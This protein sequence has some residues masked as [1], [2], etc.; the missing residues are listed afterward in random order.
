[1]SYKDYSEKAVKEIMTKVMESQKKDSS[2]AYSSSTPISLDEL[3]ETGSQTEMN[4][5][6]IRK[7]AYEYDHPTTVQS[8]NISSTHIT[9]EKSFQSDVSE[10]IIWNEIL[11]ELEHYFADETPKKIKLHPSEMIWTHIDHANHETVVSLIKKGPLATLK[12]SKRIGFWSPA[13]EGVLH[14][15]YTS[16]ILFGVIFAILNPSEV[17]SVG[18]LVMLWT[19][20]ATTIF[21]LSSVTRRRKLDRLISITDQLMKRIP[22]AISTED[23]RSA[24]V[25]AGTISSKSTI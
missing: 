19:L 7:A 20:I 6:E 11:N 5:D 12:I 22:S 21:K 2:E 13:V 9:I 3:V 10:T 17:A 1:M 18:I 24:E 16:L 25:D 23:K 15:A 4:A 14:G 8:N